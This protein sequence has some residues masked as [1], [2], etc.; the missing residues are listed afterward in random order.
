MPRQG[1]WQEPQELSACLAGAVP[2]A[3]EQG[4]GDQVALAAAAG[5][6]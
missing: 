2:G 1:V 4:P 3:A 6:E 5:V